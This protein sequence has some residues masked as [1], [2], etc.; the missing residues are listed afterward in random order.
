MTEKI[1]P[2]Y[3]LK[4][5]HLGNAGYAVPGPQRHRQGSRL[6]HLGCISCLF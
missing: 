5:E 1:H 4:R 6:E 2:D 3:R